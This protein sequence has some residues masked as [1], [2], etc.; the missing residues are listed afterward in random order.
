MHTHPPTCSPASQE[1]GGSEI[2]KPPLLQLQL[3]WA[4]PCSTLVLWYDPEEQNKLLKTGSW[5]PEHLRLKVRESGGGRHQVSSLQLLFFSSWWAGRQV[6]MAGFP[7]PPTVPK[8]LPKQSPKSFSKWEVPRISVFIG[9]ALHTTF[10]IVAFII[11]TDY[12]SE[13]FLQ[14][15]TCILSKGR[16][17]GWG[18]GRLC[19]AIQSLI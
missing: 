7:L 9:P 14:Q 10:I 5:K 18:G 1:K 19:V 8:K 12:W 17:W 16:T 3:L 11:L 15:N 6:V 2:N 13:A 4:Q